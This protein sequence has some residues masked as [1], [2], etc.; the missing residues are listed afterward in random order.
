MS[1]CWSSYMLV[2]TAEVLGNW[3]GTQKSLC[4]WAESQH[5]HRA[6]RA[7]GKNPGNTAGCVC[8]QHLLAWEPFTKVL[9]SSA[10]AKESQGVDKTG[11]ADV[12]DG[13][14]GW[15]SHIFW[16][17]QPWAGLRWSRSV[18]KFG[19][20]V[21]AEAAGEG[22]QD[23]SHWI[24]SMC[25]C[26]FLSVCSVWNW[27]TDAAFLKLQIRCGGQFQVFSVHCW[28]DGFRSSPLLSFASYL[29]WMIS[30]CYYP[31]NY[32]FLS[33]RLSADIPVHPFFFFVFFSEALWSSQ[34]GT[35]V[36]GYPTE[37]LSTPLWSKTRG[38]TGRP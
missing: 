2:F 36:K 29:W 5:S 33:L 8:C 28:E 23:C 17:N 26:L 22:K 24:T 38:H 11:R 32:V 34:K 27:S 25:L 1:L 15:F 20:M 12:A 13:E 7:G 18:E 10:A 31:H 19:A 9:H 3:E 14:C 37:S 6:V 4:L 30:M 21:T 35:R 16:N